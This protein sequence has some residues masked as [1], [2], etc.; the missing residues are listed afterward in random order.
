MKDNFVQEVSEK[1]LKFAKI[2]I[3]ALFA[4]RKMLLKDYY[5]YTREFFE[6][7]PKYA[8]VF[9]CALFKQKIMLHKDY[10]FS[11]LLQKLYEI[12]IKKNCASAK[13]FDFV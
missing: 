4:Q 13:N 2:F 5:S 9:I 10:Y 1:I 7:I 12:L 8:K 6:K 3:P 11:L